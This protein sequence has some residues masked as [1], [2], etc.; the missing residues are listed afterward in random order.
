MSFAYFCLGVKDDAHIVVADLSVRVAKLFFWGFI[1]SFE[2]RGV[3]YRA[4][5]YKVL[6][7]LCILCHER[8]IWCIKENNLLKEYK[9]LSVEDGS[10]NLNLRS[11]PLS[12]RK[13]KTG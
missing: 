2:H 3:Y 1:D 4:Y 11:L 13:N 12:W 5:N 8:F 9:N 7:N 10:E 6:P